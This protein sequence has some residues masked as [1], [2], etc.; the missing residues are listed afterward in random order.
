MH[1]VLHAPRAAALVGAASP[2]MIVEVGY[3]EFGSAIALFTATHP[4]DYDTPCTSVD[5]DLYSARSTTWLRNE[6]TRARIDLDA[7][8]QALRADGIEVAS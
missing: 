1:L 4:D 8:V 7:F 3:R 5:V 2:R 6:R